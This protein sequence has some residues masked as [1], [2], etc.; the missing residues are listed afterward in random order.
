MVNLVYGA[1]GWLN[2]T[3]EAQFHVQAWISDGHAYLVDDNPIEEK[4]RGISVFVEIRRIRIAI[5]FVIDGKLSLWMK[6]VFCIVSYS[7]EMVIQFPTWYFFSCH[8]LLIGT[9]GCKTLADVPNTISGC[10]LIIA[11]LYMQQ[12]NS[13]QH[14]NMDGKFLPSLVRWSLV[15]SKC[16]EWIEESCIASQ[17]TRNWN[18]TH[19][20]FFSSSDSCKGVHVSMS[21]GPKI[22]VCA[23]GSVKASRHLE[24]K[25]NV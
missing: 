16:W 24:S 22:R 7:M 3:R 10:D 17:V 18:C 21:A 2:Y 25:W 5:E 12:R 23:L 20:F 14:D 19:K 1:D 8:F 6:Q 11:P 9:F 15:R 13:N 4:G